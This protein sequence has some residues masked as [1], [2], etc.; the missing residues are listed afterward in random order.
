MSETKHAPLPFS[1]GVDKYGEVLIF[2]GDDQQIATINRRRDDHGAANAYAKATADLIA[3]AV[4]AR[5]DLVA[6]CGELLALVGDFM[7][8]I[9]HCSLQ[10][11]A[12]MNEAPIAGRAA[13]AKATGKDSPC[14]TEQPASTATPT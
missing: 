9:A 3:R 7:R 14:N 6:A 5:E 4:N 11:Y 8:N 13:I 1:V 2:G 10:N 12:R